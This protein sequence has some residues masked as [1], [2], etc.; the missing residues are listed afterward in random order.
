[1][2]NRA[3]SRCTHIMFG[4]RVEVGEPCDIASSASLHEYITV[5]KD[6]LVSRLMPRGHVTSDELATMMLG[7]KI[8]AKK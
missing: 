3:A 5:T 4:T 6:V 2:V 8:P 7:N 1:M